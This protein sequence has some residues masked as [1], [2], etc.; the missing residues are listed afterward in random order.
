MSSLMLKSDEKPITLT[1]DNGPDPEVTPYVLDI[2]RRHDVKSTFFVVGRVLAKNRAPAERARDEGHWIGNHT[3]SH[4]NPFRERGDAAFVADEID[5]TQAE[6]G[7]LAHPDRLFRPYGGGGRLDG[8]LNGVAVN[9]LKRGGYS[10][11]L[12]NCVPG[13]FRDAQGWPATAHQQIARNDWPLV[14]LHDV[15]AEAM[16]NL[17]GFIGA[18]KDKGY[19]FRQ[20]FPASTIA[21][22][23]GKPTPVLQTGVLVSEP[24]TAKRMEEL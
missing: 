10:C 6:L 14:V 11:I 18:L 2:L 7:S 5:S 12:W 17:D 23:N 22:R 8:A 21:I 24:A 3:W 13:D 19:T 4:S 9:H 15:H 20:N 16:T 1:F